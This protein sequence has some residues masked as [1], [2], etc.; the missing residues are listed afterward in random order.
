MI[1]PAM[2]IELAG[3]ENRSRRSEIQMSCLLRVQGTL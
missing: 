3:H 1:N 2:I